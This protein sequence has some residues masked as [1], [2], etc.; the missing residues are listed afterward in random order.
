MS[1]WVG[2]ALDILLIVMIGAGLVQVSRLIGHLVGLKKSRGEMERFVHEF[3][4]TVSRAEAGIKALKQAARDSGDDLEHLV[5]KA[6]MI[7]DELKFIVDSADQLAER[8]TAA[9]S[10]A[11]RPEP[12]AKSES[13]AEAK[14]EPRIETPPP[15][16][17]PA[18]TSLSSRKQE[19]VPSSRAEKE[20]LQALQKLK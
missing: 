12:K 17:P 20:L 13:R 5:D 2:P 8:L 15:A 10:S 3:G 4:S 9:A 14:P 16:E 11:V 19:T 18:V 6:G 7:R 1:E